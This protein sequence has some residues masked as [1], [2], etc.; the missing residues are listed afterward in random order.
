M[1]HIKGYMYKWIMQ[2]LG[3]YEQ[4]LLCAL[5]K[6]VAQ[7]WLKIL[8]TVRFALSQVKIMLLK[9]ETNDNQTW[10]WLSRPSLCSV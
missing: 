2:D 10:S 1:V 4:I 5:P 7:K 9:P 3:E 6:H 8:V